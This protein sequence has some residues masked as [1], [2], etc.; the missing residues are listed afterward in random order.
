[1]ERD[2][3]RSLSPFSLF[4]SQSVGRWVLSRKEDYSWE[5][6]SERRWKRMR[7]R[8]MERRWNGIKPL[9]SRVYK[10]DGSGLKNVR[11]IR[12]RVRVCLRQ[13]VSFFEQYFVPPMY[14][15]FSIRGMLECYI[16]DVSNGFASKPHV[17][18]TIID[19]ISFERYA[20]YFS[21]I[22]PFFG[23]RRSTPSIQNFN[24]E[25]LE[26]ALFLLSS[27]SLPLSLSLL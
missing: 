5:E 1:M 4:H 21:S 3:Y 9:W 7:E 6:Y 12:M 14:S 13:C 8:E 15:P 17:Y 25:H 24:R 18:A 11:N 16:D 19:R 22:F 10:M 27:L 23:R 2:I 26:N 20:K